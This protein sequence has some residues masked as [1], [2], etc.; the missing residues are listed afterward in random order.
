MK[1]LTVSKNVLVV[2]MKMLMLEMEVEAAK[3]NPLSSRD[4]ERGKV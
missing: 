4:A 1:E 3:R 2:T